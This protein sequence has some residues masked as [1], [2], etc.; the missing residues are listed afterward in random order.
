MSPIIIG[1]AIVLVVL[2]ICWAFLMASPRALA[3]VLRALVTIALLLLAAR[4]AM[5]GQ[6]Q[7]AILLAGL[8]AMAAGIVPSPFVGVRTAP[9]PGKRSM[10]RS[11]AFEMEL[12]HDTGTLSGVVIA[13]R[14]EG[15]VLAQLSIEELGALWLDLEADGESRA[16]LEAYLDRRAPTWR[17]DVNAHAHT[18]FTGP[19]S[20]GPMTDQEAYQILGLE[21]GAHE[22]EIREAH[23]RLMMAVHPDRGGSTFLA[24]RI[25]EAKD[26]LLTKHRSSPRR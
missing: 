21:P 13:G 14:Y 25:N 7:F 2:G 3:R 22:T 4:L 6:I 15:R 17:E 12:D 26:I 18:R 11:A 8:A 9:T 19:P 10:V 24:A 1:A 23:R 5:V 20:T 16:L